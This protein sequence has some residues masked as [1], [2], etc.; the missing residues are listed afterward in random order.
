MSCSV[1]RRPPPLAVSS[2][3][4]SPS[5]TCTAF[6]LESPSSPPT[7]RT[8]PAPNRECPAPSPAARRP[9]PLVPQWLPRLQRVLHSLLSLLRP[10]QHQ[11]RFP[12]Q[13]ENVLLRHPPP[14][15]PRR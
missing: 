7:S 1:T 4:A 14:A 5:S 8:L 10:H 11:E 9:S 3:M 13:I 15:A 6:A 2:S 12:L